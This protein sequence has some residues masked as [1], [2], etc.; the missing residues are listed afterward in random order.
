[1]YCIMLHITKNI[2]YHGMY[3]A[4]KDT[5]DTQKCH[6]RAKVAHLVA[7]AAPALPPQGVGQ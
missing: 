7:H 5:H 3:T 4:H 1:M 6:L 2:I